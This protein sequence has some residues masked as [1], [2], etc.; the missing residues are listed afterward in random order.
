MTVST[1]VLDATTGKPAAGVPVSLEVRGP[2]WAPVAAGET[3]SDGRLRFGTATSPGVYRLTFG[4]GDYFTARGT[5]TFYP[6]VSVTFSVVSDGHVHVPLLL[7]PF[8][9]STYRGSL[10]RYRVAED[11]VQRHRPAPAAPCYRG[12][13]G[14]WLLS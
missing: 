11:E 6:E 8:G 1:H 4:T 3:D 5:E 14:P 7:S 13:W 10:F 12:R 2:V 9:Y